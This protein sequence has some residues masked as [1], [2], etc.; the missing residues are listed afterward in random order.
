[1]VSHGHNALCKQAT[2]NQ[3]SRSGTEATPWLFSILLNRNT[4]TR[5][6]TSSPLLL[7][8][9]PTHSTTTSSGS[10]ISN[11]TEVDLDYTATTFRH[12]RRRPPYFA[13]RDYLIPNRTLS[14]RTVDWVCDGMLPLQIYH[15]A[16][17]PWYHTAYQKR[18]LLQ[19]PPPLFPYA[20]NQDHAD[21]LLVQDETSIV[22]NN[23]LQNNSP[24]TTSS[25]TSTTANSSSSSSRS[26]NGLS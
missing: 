25:T 26:T 8:A 20:D 21:A 3:N 15:A 22:H 12:H 1:L 7:R 6:T 4:A 24:T 16:I 18:L 9:T 17:G 10:R 11:N 14:V 13:S 23:I 19:Q 2:S 5:R